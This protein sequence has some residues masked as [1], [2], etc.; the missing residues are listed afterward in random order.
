MEDGVYSRLEI[1]VSGTICQNW[2]Q[3]FAAGV[4]IYKLNANLIGLGTI[5]IPDAG[6]FLPPL[7][8][9]ALAGL[10]PNLNPKHNWGPGC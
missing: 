4:P 5:R 9:R 3:L 10:N 1:G 7:Y 6:T 8:I 2:H